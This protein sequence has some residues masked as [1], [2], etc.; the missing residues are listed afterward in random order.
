MLERPPRATQ[1]YFPHKGSAITVHPGVFNV[2]K[3][4]G[5]ACLRHQHFSGRSL[6]KLFITRNKV[7]RLRKKIHPQKVILHPFVSVG[8][9]YTSKLFNLCWVSQ[10]RYCPK[11]RVN[12]SRG[13][14]CRGLGSLTAWLF[15]LQISLYRW[16]P[17]AA[18]LS[19]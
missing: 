6:P 15:L 19:Q 18:A 3:N 10:V 4:A 11:S 12:S 16:I 17:E 2:T 9:V 13:R 7:R 5:G 14:G 8:C 1:Q